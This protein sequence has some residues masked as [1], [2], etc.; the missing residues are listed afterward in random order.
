MT[1]LEQ[2]PAVAAH[3]SGHNSGVVHSGV[4]YAPGSLRA[5]CC[6]EGA[7]ALRELCSEHR[8]PLVERTGWKARWLQRSLLGEASRHR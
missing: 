6:V 8:L 4:Y 1:V 7:Q 5:R 2:E 3:Q